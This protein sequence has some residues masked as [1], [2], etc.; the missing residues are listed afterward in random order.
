M[1]K[2]VS[3]VLLLREGKAPEWTA[4]VDGRLNAWTT[5]YIQWLM[6]ADIALEE[7]AAPK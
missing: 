5:S 3:G 6:S 7:K 1:A 2:V 4:D